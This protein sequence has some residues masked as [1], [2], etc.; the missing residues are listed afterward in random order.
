MCLVRE[1]VLPYMRERQIA[2]AIHEW[3]LKSKTIAR[4]PQM[5]GKA[6]FYTR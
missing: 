1:T 4:Q 6:R 2:H 5:I 3:Q